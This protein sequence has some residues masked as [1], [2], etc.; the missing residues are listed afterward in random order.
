MS[1]VIDP[2]QNKNKQHHPGFDPK[3][4]KDLQLV[5]PISPI[6][7]KK[8]LEKQGL[9]SFPIPTLK[10]Y[11]DEDQEILDLH[12]KRRL[13]TEE[14]DEWVNKEKARRFMEKYDVK[15]KRNNKNKEGKPTSMDYKINNLSKV[16]SNKKAYSINI[17]ERIAAN[18][19]HVLFSNKQTQNICFHGNNRR[20][21]SNV[22][23]DANTINLSNDDSSTTFNQKLMYRH[24][25]AYI[26]TKSN[27]KY[28]YKVEL[29]FYTLKDRTIDREK[30]FKILRTQFDL[31]TSEREILNSEKIEADPDFTNEK[32]IFAYYKPP[33]KYCLR[34]KNIINQITKMEKDSDRIKYEATIDSVDSKNYDIHRVQVSL[35]EKKLI[36]IINFFKNM[37][38]LFLIETCCNPILKSS[39][40]HKFIRAF[41]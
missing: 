25:K 6:L 12:E 9:G 29:K 35:E 30:I 39:E 8:E 7:I 2:F 1:L 4:N 13:I 24:Y 19:D 34:P 40:Q 15:L 26:S 41:V 31:V 32:E 17:A 37:N 14:F 22:F 18:S 11:E 16:L 27:E 36:E 38:D 21:A 20:E 10:Y 28:H 3:A 33:I 23:M 5:F